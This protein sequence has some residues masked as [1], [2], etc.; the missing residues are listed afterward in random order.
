MLGY[1]PGPYQLVQD[2]FHQ[3]YR[4]RKTALRIMGS[5]VT[6]GLEIP[7]PCC[8]E[9]TPPSEGPLILEKTLLRRQVY[10]ILPP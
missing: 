2:F 8:R 5:Q 7:E 6:G 10:Q 3:Q 1:F 9:S 4:Q